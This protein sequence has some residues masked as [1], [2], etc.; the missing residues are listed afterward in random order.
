MVF[1]LGD[2]RGNIMSKETILNNLGLPVLRV[3]YH[4]AMKA[5]SGAL[6]NQHWLLKVKK[7][8]GFLKHNQ[9]GSVAECLP[10]KQEVMVGFPY[11]RR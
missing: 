10:I 9:H 7:K 6:H 11:A 5:Q 4:H 8:E 1:L 2:C 3:R